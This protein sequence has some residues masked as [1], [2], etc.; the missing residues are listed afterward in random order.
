MADIV[1]AGAVPIV[2]GGD[3]TVPIPTMKAVLKPRKEKVGLIVFDSHL[4]LCN[5]PLNWASS[6][7]YQAFELG[8]IDPSNFVEIGMRGVRNGLY[9]RNVAKG[10]GHR[11]ITIDEIKDRGIKDVMDEAL[12]I[13]TDGT[14][15]I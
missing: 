8:K 13:A 15:G 11:Y 5:D 2:F 7:W 10:L 12:A 1:A 4:D 14:D 3:H 9:E 6:Q